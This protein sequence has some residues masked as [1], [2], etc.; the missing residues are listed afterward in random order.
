MKLDIDWQ[1]VI[2]IIACAVAYLIAS[3]YD[4]I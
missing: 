4:S 1:E 2:A 3:T